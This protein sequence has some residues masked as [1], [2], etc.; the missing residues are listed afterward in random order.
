MEA[1]H[2][3]FDNSADNFRV[4]FWR[5][6]KDRG[7]ISCPLATHSEAQRWVDWWCSRHPED[8]LRIHDRRSAGHIADS[9]AA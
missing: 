7:R 4:H 6:G 5:A 3:E 1:L 8:D 9:E 2:T